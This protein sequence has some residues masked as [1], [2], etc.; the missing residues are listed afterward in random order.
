MSDNMTAVSYVDNEGGMKSEFCNKIAEELWVWCT[1]Q[2]MWVSAAQIRGTQN[3]EADNFSIN[4]S[5][6]TEWKLSTHLFQKIS[7]IFG[8]PTLDLFASRMSYQ[9]DRYIS[10]KPVPKA[11]AIDS[12]SL[13]CNAEFYHVFPTFSLLG[14]VTGKIYRDKTKAIVVAPKWPTQNWYFKNFTH[15]TK[16]FTYKNSCSINYARHHQSIIT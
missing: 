5:E 6:T 10:W 15:Y 4:I 9:T 3:I 16:S 2:N 12:F 11:L 1:L 14:K 13:K 8:N 7:S